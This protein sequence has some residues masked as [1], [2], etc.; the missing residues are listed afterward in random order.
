MA[1]EGRPSSDA[2]RLTVVTASDSDAI[3]TKPH[4]RSPSLDCFALLAMTERA[5]DEHTYGS[6]SR[7]SIHAGASS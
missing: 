4:I 6:M 1:S 7:S 2:S 3:Q 5:V